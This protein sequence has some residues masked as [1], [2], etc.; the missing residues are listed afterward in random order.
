[1]DVLTDSVA[2]CSKDSSVV[3]SQFREGDSLEVIHRYADQHNGVVKSVNFSRSK[4]HQ[5][6]TG[7]NDRVLRVFDMNV[8]DRA[9]IEVRDAHDRAINS[10][11]FHPTDANL[12]ATAGF[13]A[14]MH[15][16]DLRRPSSPV[17]TF[18][19]H[20]VDGKQQSIIYHPVFVDNG[21]GLAAAAGSQCRHISL[22]NV[23]D[24]RTVS[25]GAIPYRADVLAADPFADR[26]LVASGGVIE[27]YRLER[28][29][30][31]NSL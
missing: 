12:V 23:Q 17:F 10:V 29:N 20:F 2:T 4:L 1:M 18:R 28:S 6:A 3:I 5:V 27:F 9:V 31:V 16:F 30:A 19:G 21:R 8:K 25:R 13:D 24:G 14:D 15:L 26:L 22:Y 7:G 11:Q